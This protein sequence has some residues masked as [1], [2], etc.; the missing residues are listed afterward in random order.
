MRRIA[1][2]LF[3]LS[4]WLVA[5]DARAEPAPAFSLRW[6]APNGCPQQAEVRDRIRAL[7]GTI[8]STGTVLQAQGTITQTDHTHFHLKLVTRAGSLVGE[9]N[10][11]ASSCENLTGAAAVSLALLLRSPEPLSE[12][13]LGGRQAGDTATNPAPTSSSTQTAG[14]ASTNATTPQAAAD[15]NAREQTEARTSN[16]SSASEAAANEFIQR[17]I[18]ASPRGWRVL[19]QVPLATLS[20]GPLPQSSWGVAFAGGAAFESWRLV[21]GGSAWLRQSMTSEQAPGYGADV[22]RLTGTFKACRAL[23]QGAFEVAPCLVLSLEHISARGTGA[24][25]TARAQQATW[26]AVGAGAQGRLYLASWLS[27]L[28]GVDAQLETSRPLLS[29]DGVGDLGQLG[30]AAFSATVGPEWIF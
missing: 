14:S 15:A 22:D 1:L 11:D 25:V 27:L 9:R 21:L 30:P 10:L 19:A 16:D 2:G 8:G 18:A 26:L 3:A 23:Q 29:I 28:V 24:G 5:E 17:P 6:Q 12:G 20:F 7:T 13:D 4:S